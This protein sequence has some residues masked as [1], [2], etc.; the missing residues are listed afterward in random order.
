ML[1]KRCNDNLIWIIPN[2]NFIRELK[3]GD[4]GLT[5]FGR[6]S[7]IVEI[8]ARKHDVYGRLFAHYRVRTLNAD[9][10]PCMTSTVTGAGFKQGELA[11][12]IAITARYLADTLSDVEQTLI[13]SMGWEHLTAKALLERHAS[14]GASRYEFAPPL[15]PDPV[16]GVFDLQ[17]ILDI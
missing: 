7:E 13:T 12:T 8:C 6:E 16:A 14:H 2:Y 3:V 9:G 17:S 4:V 10:S 11:R 5:P 15:G 1:H